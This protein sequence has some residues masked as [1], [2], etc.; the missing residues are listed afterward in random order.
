MSEIE[1][2][3][4]MNICNR[5]SNALYSRVLEDNRVNGRVKFWVNDRSIYIKKCQKN[6]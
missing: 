1:F 3:Q 2:I 5:V 6:I 4:A